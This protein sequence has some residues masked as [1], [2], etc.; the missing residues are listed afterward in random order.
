MSRQ[1]GYE[2]VRFAVEGVGGAAIPESLGAFYGGEWA[3]RGVRVVVTVM[4][5]FMTAK[6]LTRLLD[7]LR[8]LAQR[9]QGRISWSS[10]YISRV[11]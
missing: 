2:A 10:Q 4:R 7:E 11:P 6:I 1:C 3:A 5:N 9:S 8:T